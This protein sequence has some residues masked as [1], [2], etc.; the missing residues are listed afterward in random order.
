MP[1]Q[2]EI[3]RAISLSQQHNFMTLVLHFNAISTFNLILQGRNKETLKAVILQL[4]IKCDTSDHVP[5]IEPA[6]DF[7][8]EEE[9]QLPDFVD[10]ARSKDMD[11]DLSGVDPQKLNLTMTDAEH[12]D[13]IKDQLKAEELTLKGFNIKK[14]V[15]LAKY[16]RRYIARGGRL[17]ELLEHVD[18]EEDLKIDSKNKS[19]IL[20][21]NSVKN[22]GRKLMDAYGDSMLHV[23]QIFNERY[24]FQNRL[25]IS[26]MPF[27]IDKNIFQALKNRFPNEW[28]ATAA[29]QLRQPVIS[30]IQMSEF[31]SRLSIFENRDSQFENSLNICTFQDDMQFAFSYFHFIMSEK[32][33]FDI[34]KIF[35]RFDTDET[36]T[37]SDREI[38]T[39]LTRIHNL[40]LA[41]EHINSFEQAIID[42]ASNLVSNS[43]LCK[44]CTCMYVNSLTHLF[45]K[46]F[47]KATVLQVDF[48]KYFFNDEI[49]TPQFTVWKL[50][51]FSLTL[52]AKIS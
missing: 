35:R 15:I 36:G 29:H 28:E 39:L 37:W 27:L 46:N 47:V 13:I 20:N 7:D 32:E 11:L 43:T 51:K 33:S 17:E 24:G 40:P 34:K 16:V 45:D 12:L 44:L 49:I 5:F 31:E 1:V 2:D 25:A 42:C 14:S 10:N 26:H 19:M 22:V 48:T 4:T 9:M 23:N 30:R 3:V 38:R 41:L 52:F 50:Q 6:E 21:E 18:Y 8:Y